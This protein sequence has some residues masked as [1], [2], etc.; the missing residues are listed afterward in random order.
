VS[1][2]RVVV[3]VVVCTLGIVAAIVWPRFMPRYVEVAERGVV[4]DRWTDDVCTIAHSAGGN[5]CLWEA[6][7]REALFRHGL[8]WE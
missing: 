2:A 1:Q 8:R 3:A 7:D 4:V 5:V 6:D